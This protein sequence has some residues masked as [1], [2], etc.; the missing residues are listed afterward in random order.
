MSIEVE[1]FWV[2]QLR[3]DPPLYY[4]GGGAGVEA[5]HAYLYNLRESA[6]TALDDL[7]AQ[8]DELGLLATFNENTRILPAPTITIRPEP[9]ESL[10]GLV[11][12]DAAGMI[13]A[14][15]SWID[16]HT[17]L[18][19]GERTARMILAQELKV[20]VRE[21]RWGE[22]IDAGERLRNLINRLGYD[23]GEPIDPELAP[24]GEIRH[25][26]DCSLLGP[27]PVE[28]TTGDAE[29]YAVDRSRDRAEGL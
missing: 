11:A 16:R 21:L 15:S 6:Q 25:E 7:S 20:A 2:I 9:D 19:V 27:L 5:R 13:F 28:A 4:A 18:S 12:E 24:E 29:D 3:Q 23:A 17:D 22:T 26:L 1:D 10:D 14:P 8:A